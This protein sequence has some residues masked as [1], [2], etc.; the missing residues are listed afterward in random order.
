MNVQEEDETM[1]DLEL[2][3]NTHSSSERQ[4]NGSSAQFIKEDIYSVNKAIA[5]PNV[6]PLDESSHF[7]IN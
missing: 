1:N 4:G 6:L 7:I 5:M 3:V 2:R